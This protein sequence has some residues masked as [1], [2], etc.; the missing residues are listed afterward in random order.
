MDLTTPQASRRKSYHSKMVSPVSSAQALQPPEVLFR[1]INTITGGVLRLPND[2]W[3]FDER[4][5]SMHLAIHVNDILACGEEM[6]EFIQDCQ[7]D[8]RQWKNTPMAALS[9]LLREEW[10]DCLIRFKL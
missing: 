3:R 1:P 6:W 2:K 5:L 10:D 4:I 9:G 7:N 8:P